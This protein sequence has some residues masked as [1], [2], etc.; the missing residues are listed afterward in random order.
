M[1]NTQTQPRAPKIAAIDV[2]LHA[3]RSILEAYRDMNAMFVPA[4]PNNTRYQEAF[5]KWVIAVVDEA[6][7]GHTDTAS[8]ID[9]IRAL[10]VVKRPSTVQEVTARVQ[11]PDPRHFAGEPDHGL[12]FARAQGYAIGALDLRRP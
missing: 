3:Q 11:D 6:S 10:Q 2:A 5:G 12:R 1:T 7:R 8:T 9:L 4:V